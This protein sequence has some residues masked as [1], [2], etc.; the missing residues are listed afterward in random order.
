VP[1]LIRLIA[2]VA[3]NP[4]NPGIDKS[5]TT[6]SGCSSCT[7]LHFLYRLLSVLGFPTYLKRRI[8][9]KEEANRT[10]H[11]GAIINDQDSH[12]IVDAS[13]L[14]VFLCKFTFGGEP[15]FFRAAVAITAFYIELV[16]L[17]PNLFFAGQRSLLAGAGVGGGRRLRCLVLGRR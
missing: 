7:F 8:P 5:I 10:S 2:R 11:D 4:F 13:L 3:S 15:I 17:L 14:V 6:R 9:L 16:G 1:D 12:G